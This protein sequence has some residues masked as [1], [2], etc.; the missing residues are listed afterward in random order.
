ME[1]IAAVGAHLGAFKTVL[2]LSGFA[3]FVTYNA[4]EMVLAFVAERARG[5][6]RELGG[7]PPPHRVL[8]WVWTPGPSLWGYIR[9]QCG[10]PGA[11]KLRAMLSL[12]ELLSVAR[13]A[14]LGLAIALFAA[15]AFV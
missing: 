2:I 3:A 1:T 9:S 14:C 11:E 13:G 10:Q 5:L 15:A 12:G 7:D 4:V 6:S 8:L